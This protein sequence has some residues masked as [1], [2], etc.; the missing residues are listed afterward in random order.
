V[1][2]ERWRNP[3]GFCLRTRIERTNFLNHKITAMKRTLFS[4]L[5]LLNSLTMY[6][7][8]DV[9]VDIF[10]T[11]RAEDSLLFNVGYNACDISQFENLVSDDFE[12]YHDKAGHYLFKSGL[13]QRH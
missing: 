6:P 7:Q 8:I 1:L 2:D 3:P 9:S 5:L 12:I 4:L 13:Y 10:K 11:I